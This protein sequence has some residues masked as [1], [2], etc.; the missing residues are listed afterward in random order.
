[1]IFLVKVDGILKL[2]YALDHEIGT[3]PTDAAVYNNS[4]DLYNIGVLGY[5]GL[6]LLSLKD[7]PARAALFNMDDRVME[8]TN[9]SLYALCF[10]PA[11]VVI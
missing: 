3:I 9:R 10:E 7:E 11:F 2:Y 8:L 1:V 5:N 4:V 6:A